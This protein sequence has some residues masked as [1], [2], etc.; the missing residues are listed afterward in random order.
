MV[1][2]RITL[3]D[4][5]MV[6]I[7]ETRKGIILTDNIAKAFR[8]KDTLEFKV[9][10]KVGKILDYNGYESPYR[11]NKDE[12]QKFEALDDFVGLRKHWTNESCIKDAKKYRFISQWS[13]NSSGAYQY[14]KKHKILSECTSHMEKT[15]IK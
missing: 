3:K 7:Q 15:F 2:I 9:S 14:A 10:W 11:F 5:K 8:Y 4:D 13:K 12:I 6:F 1:A